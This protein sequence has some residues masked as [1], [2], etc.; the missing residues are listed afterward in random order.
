[1]K[2]SIAL[3]REA[4]ITT[5]HTNIEI[6]DQLR[7]LADSME[8]QSKLHC[9]YVASSKNGRV[10]WTS[11]KRRGEAWIAGIESGE[12]TYARRYYAEF[13]QIL[14]TNYATTEK[15]SEVASE[16]EYKNLFHA[17]IR[18]L[19]AINGRLNLDP[20][21]GGA[22]PIIDAI[23]EMERDLQDCLR[24]MVDCMGRVE[25]VARITGAFNGQCVIEPMDS[26]TVLPTGMALYSTPASDEVERLKVRLNEVAVD[27]QVAQIKNAKLEAQLSAIKQAVDHNGKLVPLGEDTVCVSRI[28][29]QAILNTINLQP[30]GTSETSNQPVQE[31]KACK[32]TMVY[33]ADD[34]EYCRKPAQE[35]G[36]K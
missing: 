32:G 26:A 31:C 20:D 10:K 16:S 21:D 6:A 33:M 18:D 28:T 2:D 9:I 3:I 30:E 14:R 7:A 34:C 35:Q 24:S 11:D 17:A 1:M 27:W 23:D 8:A 4:A 15:S 29:W 12:Y 36:G 19:A 22:A 5:I 13:A 25:P